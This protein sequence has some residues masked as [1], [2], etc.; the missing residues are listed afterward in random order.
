MIVKLRS[1]PI[2]LIVWHDPEG[3]NTARE[4]YNYLLHIDAGYHVMVDNNELIVAAADSLQ[5]QG[6]GGVNSRS[7][8][9]CIVPG[10]AAWTR[11]T[12]MQYLPAMRL[13]AA[14]CAE[15]C[16]LHGIPPIRLSPEQVAVPGVKGICTHG[17]VSVYHPESEGHTDPGP[18]FPLNDVIIPMIGGAVPKPVVK[19]T[20]MQWVSGPHKPVAGLPPGVGAGWSSTKPDEVELVGGQ[21][22]RGDRPGPDGTRIW[23]I[24][25]TGGAHGTGIMPYGVTT[26][27]PLGTGIV[28][29]DDHGG[30][31]IGPWS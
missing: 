1:A 30:A 28:A 6:A 25:L 16:H 22:I 15:W 10:R 18:N 8:N 20:D 31:H 23:P 5:V 13:G 29:R 7:L 2:D 27:R 21:S 4:L 9:I 26:L 11:D 24:P 14:K 19:E 17:D 3:A 12:W